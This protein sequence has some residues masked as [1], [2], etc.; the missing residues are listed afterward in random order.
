MSTNQSP[1]S[2][3]SERQRRRFSESFKRNKV[4]EI[5]RGITSVSQ[6]SKLYEVSRAAVYS[7]IAHYSLNKPKQHWTIVESESD[8]RKMLELQARIAE[9]ERLVGQ[10]QIQLDF[11]NK[12][13]E[14]A[15][16]LYG[17][18]IKKKFDNKP[19]SGTGKTDTNSPAV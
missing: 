17:I 16:Q 7:W 11:N 1:K 2:T 5:D 12:M 10:K 6:I 4:K 18:D 19:S 3:R 15:E 13:I 9:L 8:T 14:L